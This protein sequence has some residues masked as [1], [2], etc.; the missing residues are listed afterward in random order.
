MD[1]EPEMVRLGVVLFSLMVNPG[2]AVTD[3][4]GPVYFTVPP[5]VREEEELMVPERDPER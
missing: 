2:V 5:R 1:Q 3:Q 4:D